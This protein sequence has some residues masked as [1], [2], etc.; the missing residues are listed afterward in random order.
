MLGWALLSFVPQAAIDPQAAIRPQTAFLEV[1]GEE[2]PAKR[3]QKLR[4]F[5]R[6][7]RKSLEDCEAFLEGLPQPLRPLTRVRPGTI[8]EVSTELWTGRRTGVVPTNVAIYLPSEF[9]SEKKWPLLIGC[10]GSGG[11]ARGELTQWTRISESTGTIVVGADDQ[12]ENSGYRASEQERV[13]QLS[14][15]RWASRRLPIDRSRVFLAG[16][17][18]GGHIVWD[19][20]TRYPD[21]WAGAIAL[22]GGPM[23][24]TVGG[25]NNLR[26]VRNLLD[27]P[28]RDLQGEQDDPGLLFN[29][30]YAFEQ[31]ESARDAKLITFPKLGH[32]FRLDAVDW[33]AFL[34]KTRQDIPTRVRF[35]CVNVEQGRRSWLRVTKLDRSIKEAYR[36]KVRA[37]E[38]NNLDMNARK[39]LVAKDAEQ[40]TAW[41]EAR[42]E[43]GSTSRRV[44]IERARGIKGVRLLLPRSLWPADV[45]HA[46]LEVRLPAGQTRK[47]AP[48]QDVETL[49]LDYCDRLD[50]ATAPVAVVDVRL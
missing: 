32:S 14:L 8:R 31:L 20:A 37:S 36:M 5:K 2:H 49:L 19:V 26:L 23:I 48:R 47:L 38:W 9:D 34:T 7:Y 50:P 6:K 44:V 17:S 46:K 3:K 39:R 28:L 33:S 11:S 24:N 10:H 42:L 18:R 45:K 1:V 35:W 21:L 12:G 25:H 22:I 27:V 15:L 41:I 29:L 16:T 43:G 4:V 30:R 13:T 40:K